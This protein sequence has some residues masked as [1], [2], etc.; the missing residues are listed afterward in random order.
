[1]IE[2]QSGEQPENHNGSELTIKNVNFPFCVDT[3]KRFDNDS[4]Y[5][6]AKYP[7][8]FDG[9]A[10]FTLDDVDHRAI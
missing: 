5:S 10:F 9:N 8:P 6:T 4:K 7:P 3:K 2:S 1:M